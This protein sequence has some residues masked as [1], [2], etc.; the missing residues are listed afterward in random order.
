M[1]IKR[2]RQQV[3]RVPVP[4]HGGQPSPELAETLAGPQFQADVQ[5]FW[6]AVRGANVDAGCGV[7]A[8]GPMVTFV[9]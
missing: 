1:A 4:A 6:L 2:P 5:M 3:P 8:A 7:L 9:P